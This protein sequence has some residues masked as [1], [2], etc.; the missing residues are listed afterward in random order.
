ME[1]EQRELTFRFE[2]TYRDVGKGGRFEHLRVSDR[3]GFH[4][5]STSSFEI[6]VE[7]ERDTTQEHRVWVSVS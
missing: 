1:H 7:L 4:H 2:T 3:N 6:D 5:S